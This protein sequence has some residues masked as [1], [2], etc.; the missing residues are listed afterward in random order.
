MKL[1]AAWRLPS[2]WLR[3][4][5]RELDAADQDQC[6]RRVQRAAI[7]N[8]KKDADPCRVGY[9]RFELDW[10]GCWRPVQSAR[11]PPVLKGPP[12]LGNEQDKRVPERLTLPSQAPATRDDRRGRSDDA[13]HLPGR[14]AQARQPARRTASSESAVDSSRQ[15]HTLACPCA[16][17]TSTNSPAAPVFSGAREAYRRGLVEAMVTTTADRYFSPGLA[18]ALPEAVRTHAAVPGA[19][20]PSDPG[21]ADLEEVP[22]GEATGLLP[23]HGTSLRRHSGSQEKSFEAFVIISD[24]GHRRRPLRSG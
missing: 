23:G 12:A 1:A 19:S 9:F 6:P 3:P 22:R 4:A 2:K 15:A 14:Q 13:R 10:S 5:W 24:G 8:G 18:R 7:H 11:L 21:E 17:A 16:N 20:V